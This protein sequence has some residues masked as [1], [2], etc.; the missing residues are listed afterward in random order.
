MQ[1]YLRSLITVSILCISFFSSSIMAHGCLA[2][3]PSGN[4][5]EK[6]ESEPNNDFQH[7]N[8]LQPNDFIIGSTGYWEVDSY[9]FHSQAKQVQIIL[10]VEN[11]FDDFDLYVYNKTRDLIKKFRVKGGDV[12]TKVVNVPAGRKFIQLRGGTKGEHPYKIKVRY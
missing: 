1:V 8:S 3:T 11:A 10:N 2:L 6:I 12:F 5:G 4:P 9:I 7:A